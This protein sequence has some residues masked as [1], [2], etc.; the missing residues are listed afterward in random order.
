[1]KLYKIT[2]MSNVTS[3]FKD[4]NIFVVADSPVI[5]ERLALSKDGGLVKNIEVLA[6]EES[7][8][9]PILII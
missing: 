8:V 7:G 9:M 2:I 3:S 5:A 6:I 4:I 1:M